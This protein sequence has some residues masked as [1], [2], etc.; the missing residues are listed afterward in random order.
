MTLKKGIVL[1][2]LILPICGYSQFAE[3]IVSARPGQANGPFGVGKNVYQIQTGFK[4]DYWQNEG[5]GSELT[6]KLF[7]NSTILR[8][9]IFENTEL[10]G[11]FQLNILDRYFLENNNFQ[12]PDQ[13]GNLESKLEN[14][15]QGISKSSLG[16]RQNIN[17][18]SGF[19]PAIGV[20]LTTLFG[21]LNDYKMN[22]V[23]VQLR[24]LLQ[25]KIL[26]K[27]VLNTNFTASLETENLAYTF[28]LSYPLT[29]KLRI[30]GEM[31]GIKYFNDSFYNNTISTNFDAG[32]GY[33]INSNFQ[34]D[35]FGGFGKHNEFH[36]EFFIS[37]GLSYRIN[38][39][40]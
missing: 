36:S 22:T 24:L 9:G 15:Q 3:K 4:Y 29:E 10:R 31:Y 28:S 39:R 27:L 21:G 23:D 32:F 25:H 30:V 1:S 19:I 14:T 34:I 20:Q 2:L 11:S 5:S 35:L 40:D 6:N 26:K 17:N 38:R 16:I 37:T 13:T 7:D 12:T 33:L 8:I 18:Q